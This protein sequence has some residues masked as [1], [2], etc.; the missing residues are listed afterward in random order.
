M[1]FFKKSKNKKL[2]V[3]FRQWKFSSF[4]GI[5]FF[6]L[7]FI[8]Y[9][10]YAFLA[11]DIFI[12]IWTSF[13]TILASTLAVIIFPLLIFFSFVKKI[14]IKNKKIIILFFLENIVLILILW[15]F[16]YFI[17]YKPIQENIYLAIKNADFIDN[18]IQKLDLSQEKENY[19]KNYLYLSE[20]FWIRTE[21]I[22]DII[23]TNKQ[24]VFFIDWWEIEEYKNRHIE[25]AKHIRSKDITVEKIK[26]VF[27]LTDSEF[28]N[29]L[30]I[31]YCNTATRSTQLTIKLDK[32]N[33]KFIING[34][35]PESGLKFYQSYKPI[36]SWDIVS[37]QPKNIKHFNKL[38][39]NT[40][41]IILDFRNKTD[42]NINKLKWSIWARVW[43]MTNEE[44]NELWTFLEKNK[45]SKIIAVTWLRNSNIFYAKILLS[46]LVDKLN[47]SIDDFNMIYF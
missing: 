32:K 31:L 46:R 17:F 38:L 37:K 13:I 39:K 29:S 23:E 9:E 24:K 34:S 20:Q 30:F 14:F 19:I 44:Y 16:F 40:N 4:K 35:N 26:K 47:Y 2:A 1:I 15:S 3:L 5:M 21:K 45:N 43:H 28:D 11:P 25:W 6:F 42:F 12:Q 10:C 18:K 7:I 8:N 36:F 27:E 22:I 41:T 33:I